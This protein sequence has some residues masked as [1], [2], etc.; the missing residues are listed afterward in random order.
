MSYQSESIAVPTSYREAFM[1][2]PQLVA[3]LLTG[4]FAITAS[5]VGQYVGGRMTHKRDE[6][7]R[8]HRDRERF[9]E[10]K[11]ELYLQALAMVSTGT[12]AEF[13]EK[14]SMIT[15]LSLFDTE[16]AAKF[17]EVSNAHYEVFSPL[18]QASSDI[19]ESIARDVAAGA[20]TGQ[21][22]A[23]R[24]AYQ[25]AKELVT[26]RL[27]PGSPE[28]DKWLDGLVEL[29]KRMRESLG[30]TT[31]GEGDVAIRLSRPGRTQRLATGE[32]D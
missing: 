4:V 7:E 6:R 25:R 11:R 27:D 28:M 31:G 24:V 32:W 23:E 2:W 3:I 10:T 8:A 22:E 5:A 17:G 20:I 26:T 30:V 9:S 12:P 1:T 21:A 15:T 18:D 14:L 16:V 29:G 13:A 19:V